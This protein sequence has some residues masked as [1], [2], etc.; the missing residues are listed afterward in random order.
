[1]ITFARASVEEYQRRAGH[2]VEM[3]CA[4]IGCDPVVRWDVFLELE[5]RGMLA[6]VLA[7][8]DDRVVGHVAAHSSVDL[9]GGRRTLAVAST[10]VLPE[11][12][13]RVV[14]RL[15]A[16]VR[17]IAEESGAETLR[18]PA[19]PGSTFGQVLI[20]TGMQQ[21]SAIFERQLTVATD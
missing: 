13:F 11:Y 16:E 6:V 18:I 15:L 21:V 2:L 3:A 20:R 10:Y 8:D 9:F 19:L 12:R 14:Q 4:E 17:D 5:R 7:C 1:M